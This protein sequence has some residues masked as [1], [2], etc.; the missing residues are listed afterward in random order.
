MM[1]VEV[2]ME[3]EGDNGGEGGKYGLVMAVSSRE[4]CVAICEEEW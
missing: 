4:C 3:G 1:G 2:E